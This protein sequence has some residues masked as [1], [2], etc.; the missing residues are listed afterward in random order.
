MRWVRA[1]QRPVFVVG[2]RTVVYAEIPTMRKPVVL[3]A[4]LAPFLVCLFHLPPIFLLL[5]RVSQ[6][7]T[8]SKLQIHIS[9]EATGNVMIL[10][11]R[12]QTGYFNYST[13]SANLAVLFH[14]QKCSSR[15]L[16]Y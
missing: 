3:P 8:S 16:V 2:V 1:L 10:F 5:S 14:R 13:T 12:H 4:V 9:L 7:F 6:H 11:N 15:P